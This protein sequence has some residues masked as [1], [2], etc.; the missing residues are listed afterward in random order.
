MTLK[1]FAIYGWMLYKMKRNNL[2][3]IQVKDEDRQKWG[4]ERQK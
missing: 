2:Y 1:I 3:K 4:K